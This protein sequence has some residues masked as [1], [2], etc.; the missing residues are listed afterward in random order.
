MAKRI[1]D[2]LSSLFPV[3]IF[4]GILSPLFPSKSPGP[5]HE[6]VFIHHE[7]T[8]RLDCS[9]GWKDWVQQAFTD[10]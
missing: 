9:A 2:F 4:L 10:Y 5:G 6:V 8:S 3:L 1:L 7:H